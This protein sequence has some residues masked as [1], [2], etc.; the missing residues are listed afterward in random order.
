[1]KHIDASFLTKLNSLLS[2]LT[3]DL[4]TNI[5]PEENAVAWASW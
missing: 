3:K 4:G 1:M 5:C 2:R